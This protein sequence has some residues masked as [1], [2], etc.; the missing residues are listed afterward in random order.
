MH[1]YGLYR[2][3][4]RLVFGDD[5]AYGLENLPE[6]VCELAIDAFHRTACYIGWFVMVKIEDAEA[7]QAGARINAKYA[8][9]IRKFILRSAPVRLR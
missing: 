7:S 6:P 1:E 8:S 4:I 9:F 5:P 2:D 3:D